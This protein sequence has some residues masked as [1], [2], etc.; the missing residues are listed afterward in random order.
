MH[1]KVLLTAS[2]LASSAAAVTVHGAVVFTRHGDR[3]RYQRT[4]ITV[5]SADRNRYYQ[6]V[7]GSGSYKSWC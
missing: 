7:Q 5:T 2:T 1:T 3:K 4:N 6:M